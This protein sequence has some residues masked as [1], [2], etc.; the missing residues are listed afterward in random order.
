MSDDNKREHDRIFRDDDCCD[1]S[2]GPGALFWVALGCAG[3]LLLFV[4]WAV[5]SV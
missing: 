2:G 5:F 3:A 4:L 1:Y